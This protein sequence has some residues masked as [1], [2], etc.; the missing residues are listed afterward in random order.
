MA[1]D[2]AASIQ[3]CDVFISHRGPDTKR[4]LVS[5]I[6]HKL[7]RFNLDVFTDY[8]MEKGVKSWQTVLEKLRGAHR[9]LL[10]LS[11]GFEDSCWCLEELRVMAE[12]SDAVLAIFV[13][14]DTGRWHQEEFHKKLE[15]AAEKLRRSQPDA[16]AD[17]VEQWDRAL[18]SIQ[19]D[20][21]WRHKAKTQYGPCNALSDIACAY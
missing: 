6:E 7:R 14:V 13:D 10:V 17:I 16:P 2:A 18:K 20:S 1:R 21:G 3:A 11:P 4:S 5:H 19:G 12:R 15:I 9:V 8:S